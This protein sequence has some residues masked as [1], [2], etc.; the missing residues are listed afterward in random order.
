MRFFD[1]ALETIPPKAIKELQ[2]KKFHSMFIDGHFQRKMGMSNRVIDDKKQIASHYF[3][4]YNNIIP[5]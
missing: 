5:P 1:H 3:L 2:I 4:S